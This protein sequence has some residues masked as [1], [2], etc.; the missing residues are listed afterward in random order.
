[1]LTSKVTTNVQGIVE[2]VG[3]TKS[4]SITLKGVRAGIKKFL[5][6][7]RAGAPRR[8]RSGALK[9]SQAVKSAKGKKGKTLSYA[10]QGAKTGFVKMVTPQGYRTPQKA[11]PA[12]Y[13]HLVQGGTKG[14][15]LGKGESLG[16]ESVRGRKAVVRTGQ[17][18]GGMHPGTAPN[19]YRKRAWE[20][21]KE[22]VGAETTRVMILEMQAEINKQN[23]K[24][25]AH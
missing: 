16:R 4:R 13:D 12:F 5:P 8:K 21:S 3:V 1:M 9:Q 10:V 6:L 7:A 11:V 25:R 15:R 24:A 20:V 18:R 2:L 17:L 23:S 19:P 22:F 14:H